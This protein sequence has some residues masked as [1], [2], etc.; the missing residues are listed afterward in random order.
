MSV[1]PLNSRGLSSADAGRIAGSQ[2][3][4]RNEPPVEGPQDELAH[5]SG[6]SVELSAASRTLVDRADGAGDVPQGTVSS[7]RM[8]EV[9]RRLTDG[10]YDGAAVRAEVARRVQPDLG[11]S[12]PE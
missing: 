12:T 7:T 11:L 8:Q 4:R 10:Y 5:S 6:D 3:A 1:D 2:S 9:L